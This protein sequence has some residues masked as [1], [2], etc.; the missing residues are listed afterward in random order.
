MKKNEMDDL[1]NFDGNSQ[2]SFNFGICIL[3]E[4]V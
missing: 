1:M 4:K 3:Y 2:G